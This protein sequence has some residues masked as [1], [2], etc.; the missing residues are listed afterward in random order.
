MLLLSCCCCCWKILLLLLTA[1]FWSSA[2]RALQI[3]SVLA[4]PA[5]LQGSSSTTHSRQLA[6][7]SRKKMAGRPL[8]LRVYSMPV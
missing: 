7:G 6:S 2:S 8:M 5:H 1:A 4:G 3:G